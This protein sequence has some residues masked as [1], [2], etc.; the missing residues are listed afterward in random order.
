MPT[1][2]RDEIPNDFV[3]REIGIMNQPLEGATEVLAWA[4]VSDN[5]IYR[6][7]S[8]DCRLFPGS[9]RDVR[10]TTSVTTL[11]CFYTNLECSCRFCVLGCGSILVAA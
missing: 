5:A 11:C 3:H 2:K 4:I 1:L 8:S 10:V 6:H 7:L 9:Q